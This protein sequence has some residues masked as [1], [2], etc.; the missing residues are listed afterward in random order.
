MK[1]RNLD[2]GHNNEFFGDFIDQEPIMDSIYG[3]IKISTFE[4]RLISTKEMQ[5]LRGIK[6][7][8]FVNL[9]YPDAEHSR[10]AH[11]LGVCHQSKI[12]IE[13]VNN[14]ISNNSNY[15]E[16]LIK[17]YTNPD[18]IHLITEIER[19]VISASALLHDIPHSPFSHE[20][21]TQ[22]T[23]GS[24]IPTHDDYANNH[25]FYNYLFNKEAHD[26]A[27]VI[28]I[29]N[30]S[31]WTKVKED[32][33]W[34]AILLDNKSI[35]E[36]GYVVVTNKKDAIIE[37]SDEKHNCV[38]P[39][40]GVMIFEILLYDSMEMWVTLKN[41]SKITE[42][43]SGIKIN[44]NNKADKIIW[45][46]INKWFRPYR[47]DIIANTICADLLDYL[48]R[49]GR[50]TGIIPSLDLKFFD[51][52][53]IAKAIPEKTDTL[54]PLSK[55]PDFCEHIVFDIFD[56]KRGVIRQSIITEIVSFLQ[57]RYLLAERVYNHRV[58]EGARTMLKEASSLLVKTKIINVDILHNTNNNGSNPI[59]DEAFISW[60]LNYNH[61]GNR[62]IILAQKLI[63]MLSERR[64][65]R[66]VVI[67]DGLIGAHKGTY[68]GRD[69][70]CKT[71]ADA[72]LDENIRK[73]IISKLNIK[74]TQYCKD[75][76][77][78]NIPDFNNETIFTI[79]VRKFGKRYKPPRVLVV[80]PLTEDR[81]NDIEIF[82][83]FEG[84]KL[85]S[86]ND[87]LES[88]EHAFQ[89]LWKLY[90]FMHPFFHKNEF[91][92]L[93]KHISDNFL[94]MLYE[95]TG[96]TWE[97]SISDY[98]NLLPE[99][100][101][102]IPTF[103]NDNLIETL[104]DELIKEFINNFIEKVNYQVPVGREGF[105]LNRKKHFKTINER[106]LSLKSNEQIF[107]NKKNRENIINEISNFRPDFDIAATGKEEVVLTQ[108]INFVQKVIN[109]RFIIGTDEKEL[110]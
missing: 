38:L 1:N 17:F 96:I 15:K 98:N 71:L 35:N 47:K 36:D 32:K 16:W 23:D 82:P 30:K 63:K 86:I 106:I 70:D 68:R 64:I 93:H 107:R 100:S 87:R 101:I 22:N 37:C 8:G 3:I 97:N 94:A 60:I 77:F 14:N 6:Q 9:V 81:Q 65:F 48:L 54:I 2:P 33:K 44:I 84:K 43:K 89:S 95:S 53:T 13:H 56:H 40:L 92:G 41:G 39:L 52:M 105:K 67:I 25:T 75:K 21:E 59:N 20:I 57:Q 69:V 28:D 62:N 55:I 61:E 49:D 83:L 58:V 26:L 10:F 99:D 66:E 29:Y 51:R 108:S 46:P 72:L 78:E 79:G 27:Q 109:K 80:R 76:N 103:I 34:G 102:D 90:L 24:G 18:Q 11:S 50:N 12:M 85:P 74:V 110:F 7:L 42:N 91:K 31:F 45:K 104:S 19:I 4:K 5:R 73:D 88:M